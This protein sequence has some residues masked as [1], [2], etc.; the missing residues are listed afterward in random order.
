MWELGWERSYLE[1]GGKVS[2][3]KDCARSSSNSS[4]EKDV[5]L[6]DVVERLVIGIKLSNPEVV[7]QEVEVKECELSV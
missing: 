2:V 6:T 3:F 5:A 7:K 4:H 1:E